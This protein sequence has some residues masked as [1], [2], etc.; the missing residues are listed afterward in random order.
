MTDGMVGDQAMPDETFSHFCY[1]FWTHKKSLKW[2]HYK[3]MLKKTLFYSLLF[4]FLFP[5]LWNVWSGIIMARE[6]W[7][8]VRLINQIKESGCQRDA[9]CS[10]LFF[11]TPHAKWNFLIKWE[12]CLCHKNI[13]F[14]SLLWVISKCVSFGEQF[15]PTFSSAYFAYARTNMYIHE[16]SLR[17]LR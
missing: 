17:Y 16:E 8:R 15:F 3:N 2:C 6:A 1:H 13:F 9:F 7:D 10:T 5:K 4:T 12:Y 11:S 14:R